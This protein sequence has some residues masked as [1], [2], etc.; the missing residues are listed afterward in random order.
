MTALRLARLARV[1]GEVVAEQHAASRGQRPPDRLEELVEPHVLRRLAQ[2]QDVVAAVRLE[3][4]EAAQVEA[5]I[6]QPL[7]ELLAVVGIGRQAFDVVAECE[8]PFADRAGA[9]ADVEHGGGPRRQQLEQARHEALLRAPQPGH[10]ERVLLAPD[11]EV[12]EVQ[13]DDP[14]QELEREARLHLPRAA[15]VRGPPK[16]LPSLRS[17]PATWRRWNRSRFVRHPGARRWRDDAQTHWLESLPP[18]SAAIGSP[19][20][21]GPHLLR[22]GRRKDPATRYEEPP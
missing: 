9:A 22:G 1:H 18:P 6:R 20:A 19:D 15:T 16:Q 14:V 11:P 10:V 2:E 7:P 4:L 13:A 21:T 8:Q 3:L 17:R 12:Q 5:P